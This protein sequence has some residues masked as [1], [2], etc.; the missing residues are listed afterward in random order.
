MPACDLCHLVLEKVLGEALHILNRDGF[1]DLN[2]PVKLLAIAI[3]QSV[4]ECG[5][6]GVRGSSVGG[7][8]HCAATRPG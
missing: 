5:C 3:D 4:L 6:K 1:E 8:I 7:N 2:L